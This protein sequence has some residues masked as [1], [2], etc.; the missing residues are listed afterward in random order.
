MND[1]E[2]GNEDD[3]P[4]SPSNRARAVKFAGPETFNINKVT[5]KDSDVLEAVEKIKTAKT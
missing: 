4:D 5:F 3:E 1:S 2:Y